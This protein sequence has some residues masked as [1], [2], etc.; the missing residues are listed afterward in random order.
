MAN[1]RLQEAQAE[2]QRVADRCAAAEARCDELERDHKLSI[3]TYERRL[4]ELN[5]VGARSGSIHVWMNDRLKTKPLRGNGAFACAFIISMDVSG[6]S[7]TVVDLGRPW[8][9]RNEP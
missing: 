3:S 1:Q 9:Q 4:S 7:Q 6:L 5:Q 2:V 8:L